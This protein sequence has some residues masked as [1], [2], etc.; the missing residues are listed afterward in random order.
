[1]DVGRLTKV[2]NVACFLLITAFVGRSLPHLVDSSAVLSMS[3]N[4]TWLFV[5]LHTV[6]TELMLVS[7]ETLSAV[8]AESGTV[9]TTVVISFV[10][11]ERVTLA[12]TTDID[13]CSALKCFFRFDVEPPLCDK[14]VLHIVVV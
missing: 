8:A 3:I 1:M 2:D 4:P 10:F 5:G 7:V 13:R 11:T 6:A 12:T 9:A 14:T